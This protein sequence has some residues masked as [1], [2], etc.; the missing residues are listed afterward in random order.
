MDAEGGAT[1]EHDG[2]KM[3]SLSSLR[4][5]NEAAAASAD[6]VVGLP[7]FLPKMQTWEYYQRKKFANWKGKSARRIDAVLTMFPIQ[8][9]KKYV[10]KYL[11][12]NAS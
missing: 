10:T 3:G 12:H 6:C 4:R 7:A 5:K 8:I 11:G 9:W 1:N 2:W